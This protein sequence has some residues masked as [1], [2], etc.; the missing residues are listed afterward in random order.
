MH[1]DNAILLSISCCLEIWLILLLVK[2]SVRSHL[3]V[4]FVYCLVSFPITIARLLANS[5]YKVYFFVYWVSDIFLLFFGLAALH[6][7]FRWVY[8]GFY[9]FRWFQL[10]YFGS[11][12]LVLLITIRNALVNP[13]IEAYPLFGLVLDIG[14]A[15][16]LLQIGIAALFAVLAKPLA[17]EHRRYPFRIVAGF[18]VSAIGPFIGYFSRSI[19]G[20]TLNILAQ[21]FSAMSYILTLGIWIA[22]FARPEPEEE[23]WMP[24]MPPE[25]MLRLVHGYL[26]ALGV[27]R[28]DDAL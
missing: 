4:F 28:K 12:V 21:Y 9:E 5:H 20:T 14:I 17:I 15:V 11:I 8:E 7:V 1:I 23:A 3:P 13:P 10:F 16:N 27:K 26:R 18:A 22:A 19:F 24:P 2:R 6:E 25:E